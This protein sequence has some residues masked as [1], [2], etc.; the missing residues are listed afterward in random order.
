MSHRLPAALFTCLLLFHPASPV[1]LSAASDILIVVTPTSGEALQGSVSGKAPT[2]FSDIITTGRESTGLIDT[3]ETLRHASSVDLSDYGGATPSPLSVRGSNFQ[4]TLVMIDGIP[5]NQVTGDIVDLSQYV[6]PDIEQIEV[7]RGS[8]SASFGKAAMG[9]VV[10]LVTAGPS[11]SDEYD[12]TA[13]QGT[14]GYGLYHGHVSITAGEV[15]ILA[16]LTHS[17]ADN[18]FRYQRDDG[19]TARRDNNGYVNTTGLFKA[20]FDVQGWKTSLMGNRINQENGSP[21]GEGS[22]GVITPDDAVST[23][24]DTYLVEAFRDLADN[25]SMKLRTW[26]LVNRTHTESVFGDGRQKLV[27]KALVLAYTRTMGAIELSPS[28]EYLHERMDSD[29]YGTHERGTG[30]GVLSAGIDV[31]P[32]CLELSGRF[33]NSSEF[34]DRWSYHAGAAWKLLE[35]VQIKAN[36]GTGYREPTM[37]QLYA[38]STWYTFIRNPE[39]EPEKSLSY[40]IGPVIALNAVGA[41]VNYFRT[42]Y[43]DLI[44]MDFPEPEAFTYINVDK[45]LAQGIEAHAWAAPAEKVMLS[46]NYI[47]SRYTYESGPYEGNELGQKPSQVLNLQADF[48]PEILDRAATLTVSYQLRGRSYQDEANT[49]RTDSR[50]LLNAAVLYDL[51]LNVNVSFKVDNLFDDQTPEYVS[52]T[53]WGTFYYPVAGRTYRF[54]AKMSF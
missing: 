54:A 53:Q 47:L 10:N 45:V 27:D 31:S 35:Q 43:R 32:V 23:V 7:I 12:L 5:L 48:Y 52:K 42:T 18:D 33:D 50:Y 15:G 16:N 14:Y 29:E 11:L 1:L 49:A 17:F 40:D 19:T 36:V 4:Q 9:G 22:A 38:P 44:K 8:N 20:A 2:S 26:M 51:G 37:G 6:M 28:L 21:G 3:E 24:Q 34:D 41:G 13:S 25:A 39:L 30:S 46:A